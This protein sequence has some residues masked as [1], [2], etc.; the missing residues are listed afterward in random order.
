MNERYLPLFQ[1]LTI[2]S[3]TLKNRIGMTAMASMLAENGRVTDK[4]IAYFAERAKGGAGMIMTD[5]F[6]CNSLS[7]HPKVPNLYDPLVLAGLVELVEAVH[8]GGSKVCIQYGVGGGRNTPDPVTGFA[9]SS[10]DI[11]PL[12]MPDKK[13]TP[14]SVE[15]LHQMVEEI[16]LS[17]ANIKASG[18][19]AIVVHAHNGYLLD[20]FMSSGWNH[21]TD[22]YGGDINGRMKFPLEIIEAIRSQVG[23]DFP[24]IWRM[25][26]DLGIPGI[27]DKEE[28]LE[29]LRI[30]EKAGVS[31]IDTDCGC[32]ETINRI[33]PDYG[34]GDNT[35][36]YVTDWV[37]EA[38][39]KLPVWN[40]GNL[41]P[42]AAADAIA[43]GKLD[44]A[45]MGRA[46]LAD[47]ELPNKLLNGEED[48]I[49]QCIKCN[50]GC[51][52]RG[53]MRLCNI[54]C[55]VNAEAGYEL[56]CAKNK[57]CT[58]KNK[59]VVIGSGP[60]G[61][62]AA[63]V[64]AMR[65]ADVTLIEKSSKLGGTARAIAT[66]DW[67]YRF[68]KLFDWYELQMKKLGVKVL[69]NTEVSEDCSI[70][71]GADSIFVATGSN[72]IVPGIPGIDGKNVVN[73]LDA[74]L[75]ESLVK[76]EN[77]VVCGGGMSGCEFAVEMAEKGRKVTVIDMLPALATDAAMF[78]GF[79]LMTKMMTLG[80][81]MLTDTK[82]KAFSDEGV[83]VERDGKE[84]L[85][86]AD[87]AIHAFGISANNSLGKKLMG[88]YPGRVQ[89]IGDAY[90]V[91]CIYDAV[92]AGYN[93]AQSLI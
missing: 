91:N 80:V 79:T 6:S 28:T 65:G 24:V 53:F 92:H 66:P 81:S 85:I 16:R 13:C 60:A 42:E 50:M 38:G 39:V 45:L 64:S 15:Q 93:A 37:K 69:L 41:T 55:A 86:P 9:Y 8:A 43:A 77:I 18:A 58:A 10:C 71:E 33:F 59:V 12:G 54:S 83:V 14:L 47:P 23:P 30:L 29:I 31:A 89:I 78:N 36:L 56:R 46:L 44:V 22:E 40:A 21:R 62:E 88:K 17:S 2:G 25:S 70:L 52:T 1:P 4:M 49:R 72:P 63:R 84:E 19:D 3:M 90:K 74:H 34:L 76:G 87:T 51:V 11:A 5:G 61:L 67:K 7:P 68:R 48:D 20:N 73:V 32:Y 75:D 57:P 27:R 82:V 35:A 26:L